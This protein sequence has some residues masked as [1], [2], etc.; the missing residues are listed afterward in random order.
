[1]QSNIGMG[2]SPL[3]DCARPAEHGIMPTDLLIHPFC[4]EEAKSSAK[5]EAWRADVIVLSK[6]RAQGRRLAAS[7]LP[8]AEGV[9]HDNTD[10]EGDRVL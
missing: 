7:G 8:E 6:R 10:N 2:V 4:S 9:F 3:L 5:R 1:M